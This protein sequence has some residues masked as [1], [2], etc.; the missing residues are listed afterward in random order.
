M[1][2]PQFADRGT[3]Q[4]TEAWIFGSG[5]EALASAVYLIKDAK[6][7]PPKIHIIDKHLFS[8]RISHRPGSWSDGY[9]QFAACLPVPAGLPM[10]RLLATLPSTQS[11]GPSLLEEIQ[12]AEA[13]RV[14]KKRDVRTCFLAMTKGS[15]NHIPTDSLNL[16]IKHRIALIQ[17]LFKRETYLSQ[18][19]V[20]ELLPENF[21]QSPFWTIW[22]AQ[23]VSVLPSTTYS[24]PFLIFR[25]IWLPAV[26][27][28]S[29]VQ[30]L[31]SSIYASIPQLKYSKLPR[32]HRVLSV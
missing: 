17:I 7:H 3:T 12:T 24:T 6:V 13:N 8:E 23:C 4:D 18:R 22:S 11:Q 16:S 29:G 14:P 26:A 10:E 20:Q 21:F 9:D 31:Y 28:C 25:Q 27:Q 5:S 32:H 30:A 1:S 15:V 2:Q 19:Q